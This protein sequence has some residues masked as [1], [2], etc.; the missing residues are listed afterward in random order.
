LKPR[1][2]IETISAAVRKKGR[3]VFLDYASSNGGVALPSDARWGF[4]VGAAGSD[5]KIRSFTAAGAGLT[6]D[7]MR[8]PDFLSFDRLP[9]LSD[10]PGPARGSALAAA[11]ATG[12]TAS[13]LS[14]GLPT[15]SFPQAL[16]LPPGELLLVPEF[17]FRK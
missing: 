16:R 9:R 11:F 15:T 10:T 2:F 12:T 17:W 4:S 13:M 8:K 6:A 3:V 1:I 7:L 5:G 14:A